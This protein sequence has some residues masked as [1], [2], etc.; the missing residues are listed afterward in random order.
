M[1]TVPLHGKYARGR[2]ALVDDEDYELVMQYRW[3]VTEAKR[4]RK[5]GVTE[6]GPYVVCQ[7]RRGV[8]R[9]RMHTLI[10]GWNYVDHKDH[11]GLNNQRSN[12]R[13]ATASLNGANRRKMAGYSSVFK[14]VSWLKKQRIWVA[15]IRI[16]GQLR[17]LGRFRN[18]ADAARAYDAAARAAWGEFAYL[19]FPNDDAA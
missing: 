6:A 11:D 12:L 14:G 5:Q 1:K 10:T 15:K 18:E 3:H 13:E 17:Y 7:P 8:S 2:V 9:V 4:P 19:N 16:D